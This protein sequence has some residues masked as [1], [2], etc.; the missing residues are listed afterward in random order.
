MAP[1]A[2]DIII[3]K[4]EIFI[5]LFCY[6]DGAAAASQSSVADFRWLVVEIRA[7]VVGCAVAVE[8]AGGIA[9]AEVGEGQAAIERGDIKRVEIDEAG[10]VLDAMGGMTG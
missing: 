8:G 10:L 6:I 2:T 3:R 5:K 4:E 9:G 7:G 1:S